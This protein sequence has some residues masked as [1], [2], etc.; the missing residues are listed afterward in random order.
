MRGLDE[1]A[2][3]VR[4]L[5][6]DA[7]HSLEELIYDIGAGVPNDPSLLNALCALRA[8]LAS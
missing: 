6:P 4:P 3:I 8:A 7:M 2:V 5:V 1:Q